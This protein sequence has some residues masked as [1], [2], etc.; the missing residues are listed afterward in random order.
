MSA[1][2]ADIE[3]RMA[4]GRTLSAPA[5]VLAK[6]IAVAARA[7]DKGITVPILGCILLEAEKSILQATGSDMEMSLTATAR[8][9]C[10]TPWRAAVPA[11]QLVEAVRRLPA[12]QRATLTLDADTLTVRSGRFRAAIKCVPDENF[13]PSPSLM[14]PTEFVVQAEIFCSALA[15]T[16]ICAGASE[17]RP[18]LSGVFLHVTDDS[19]MAVA[20]DTQAL[21]R[22]AMVLPEGAE[23]MSPTIV[24]TRAVHEI[25]RALDGRE[26]ATL[27]V[28]ENRIQVVAGGIAVTSKLIAGTYPDYAQVIPAP[29]ASAL[30]VPSANLARALEMVSPF[31]EGGKSITGSRSGLVVLT[32]GESVTVETAGDSGDS[33]AAVDGAV[34]VGSPRRIGLLTRVALPPLAALGEMAHIA[35]GDAEQPLIVT[36]PQTPDALYLIMPYKV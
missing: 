14:R 34:Y 22:V 26:L 24:P 30:S 1:A 4:V 17:A 2:Q 5:G 35:I 21:A 12:D 18:Y 36:S 10:S 16:V 13:P 33:D 6:A 8:V 32:V 23:A 28:A 3:D 31:G 19:L 29:S 25:I 15:R 7:A 27:R 11:T 20:T 9:E